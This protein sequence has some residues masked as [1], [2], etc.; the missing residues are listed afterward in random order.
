M[1]FSIEPKTL[2]KLVD[3]Y[4]PNNKGE[5]MKYILFLKG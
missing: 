3:F 1:S 5:E 2:K 4:H